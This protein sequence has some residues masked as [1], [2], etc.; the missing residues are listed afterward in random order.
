MKKKNMTIIDVSEFPDPVSDA[1]LF[2]PEEE[3]EQMD[4]YTEY[5]QLSTSAPSGTKLESGF[6]CRQETEDGELCDG[7]IEV[8]QI[9]MPKQVRW[10]CRR[11]GDMGALV[12]YEGTMWDNSHLNDD[13]KER[14]LD[15]F[16]SDIKG[17]EVWEDDFYGFGDE[18]IGPFDDFEY[19]LNPYDEDEEPSSEG[20]K[21]MLE[22]DW[23]NSDSPI[24][25]NRDL[26]LKDVEQSFFF[27]N[28]RQFLILLNR[29][30]AF[31]LTRMGYLKR[32]VIRQLLEEMRWPENYIENIRKY[33]NGKLDEPD[34]WLLHGIRVLLALAELVKMDENDNSKIRFNEEHEYLLEEENAGELYR[35]LFSAYFK[36]MNLGYLGSSFE[37]PQL[38]YSIP[39]ILYKMRDA[40]KDWVPIKELVHDIL[41]FSVKIELTFAEAE[42]DDFD[43]L[44]LDL[45]YADLFAALERFA[46]LETKSTS[47]A[48]ADPTENYPDHVR[49]TE[50]YKKFVRV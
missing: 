34:I 38:Q 18:E 7:T 17:E 30:G 26:S 5:I 24:Y 15:R 44:E 46:L 20:I 27:H 25:L 29:E 40:A 22:C 49:I 43:T 36:D 39:F 13:E 8:T 11:C 9:D 45:L 23:L 12:N 31:R 4:I 28:A 21:E 2:M 47:S 19:Y 14:F 33:K 1:F 16:F 32:K 6:Y 37:F 41:L 35:L 42:G 48:P 10:K 3:E 50:L